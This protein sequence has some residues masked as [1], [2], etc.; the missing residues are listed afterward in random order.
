MQDFFAREGNWMH[1]QSTCHY[2][3]LYETYPTM[4]HI[5]VGMGGGGGGLQGLQPPHNFVTVVITGSG[6]PPPPP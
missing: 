3:E 2:Q 5:D 6:A 4:L 1:K